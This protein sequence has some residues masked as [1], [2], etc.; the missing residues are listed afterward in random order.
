[1]HRIHI[2]GDFNP[3]ILAQLR[4]ESFEIRSEWPPEEPALMEA[5]VIRAHHR[6]DESL[7]SRAAQLRLIVMQGTGLDHIDLATCEKRGIRVESTPGLNA[8]A[9]AEWAM[10]LLLNLERRFLEARELLN[11]HPW[12]RESALG[13]ELQSQTLGIL[14]FGRVGKQMAKRA[15]AFGMKVMAFDP[16][17]DARV[18]KEQGVLSVARDEIFSDCSVVSLHLPLTPETKG[19]VGHQEFKL[20]RQPITLINTARGEILNESALLEAL[21]SGFIKHAGL[22]VFRDEPLPIHHPYRR[23]PRILCSPHMA[24]QSQEAR[25]AIQKT[26]AEHLIRFFMEKGSSS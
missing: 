26:C 2:P 19:S 16:Y 22:D 23:H 14:G 11:A 15:Q 20:C 3:E 21:D 5:L 8:V 12:R 17:V 25:K 13:Q 24:G 9:A 4:S 7:L 10:L 1:M 6:V 18:F